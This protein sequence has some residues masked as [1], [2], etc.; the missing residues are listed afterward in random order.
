MGFLNEKVAIV[1]GAGQGLGFEITKAMAEEGAKVI[2]IGRTLSKLENAISTIGKDGL[3]AYRMDCGKEE[4]W[5]NLIT[6]IKENFGE[7]DIL[8]NNCS[9]VPGKDILNMD[10]D[11][12]RQVINC[13][14]DSVF[15]GMK[16]GYEVMKKGCYSTMVNVNSLAGII[17]GPG[18][19]NDAA[20][21][22]SKGGARLLTKHASYVFAKDCIRVFSFH[23]GGI[24]TPMREAYIK[25]HP[26]AAASAA[27]R[28]PLPPHCSE[29][30][31][32]AQT[33]V[34]LTSPAAKGITGSEIIYDFGQVSI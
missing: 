28:S 32:L 12:Y 24:N 23:P 20:Y 21:S 33:I 16:Y 27:L 17:G 14:L 1:T 29:P 25:D 11:L 2:L 18:S 30:A 15:L 13:N 19:G 5:K 4:D 7:I 34:Y 26:E 10:Y 22:A 8:V 6:Y 31:D 3:Y 9:I